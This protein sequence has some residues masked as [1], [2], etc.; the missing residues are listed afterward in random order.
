MKKI[1]C[2]ILLAVMCFCA[3][4]CGS[5]SDVEIPDG[6]KL[7]SEDDDLYYMFVPQTWTEDRGYGTPY[8]YYS[9]SDTSNVTVMFYLL[10]ETNVEKDENAVNPREPYIKA[11]WAE[12]EADVKNGFLAY[13]LID[14]ECK[15]CTI[16]GV[17]AKQYV[18]TVKTASEE[19][20]KCR[21]VAT[22]YGQM[23]FCITYTAEISKYDSHTADVD[24]IITE[25]KFK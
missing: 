20:Y 13:D 24:K 22:Y 5:S 23:V 18:Y 19:E 6:M 25:F 11:Y 10:E 14:E 2:F 16:D 4:S 9:G 12:F 1:F 3:V 15:D 21:A 17:Y 7:V 8:A